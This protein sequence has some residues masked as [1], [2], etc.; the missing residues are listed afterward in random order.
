MRIFA[1]YFYMGVGYFA[2]AI[3]LFFFENFHLIPLLGT[4]IFYMNAVFQVVLFFSPFVVA[5]SFREG[6][7]T[8]IAFLW[9]SVSFCAR[10]SRIVFGMFMYE[11]LIVKNMDLYEQVYTLTDWVY[12]PGLMAGLTGCFMIRSPGIRKEFWR[13]GWI[14]MACLFLYVVGFLLPLT[15]VIRG[16]AT[17]ICYL[18]LVLTLYSLWKTDLRVDQLEAE[19]D[20]IGQPEKRSTI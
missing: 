4:L 6:A 9:L 5:K 15:W 13:I 19:I 16:I 18:P 8:K 14:A 1:F 12:Y 3:P 20:I 2:T 7:W 10:L 11:G 17:R